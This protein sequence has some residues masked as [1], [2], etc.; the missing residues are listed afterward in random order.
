MGQR[1]LHLFYLLARFLLARMDPSIHHL[2]HFVP[3]EVPQESAG[4]YVQHT[5]KHVQVD[6]A[7][8]VCQ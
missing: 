3:K 4:A 8:D 7:L 5:F 2:T 6:I 1:V